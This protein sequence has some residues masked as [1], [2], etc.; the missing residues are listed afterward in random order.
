M[1]RTPKQTRTAH[2]APA[3][4]GRHIAVELTELPAR[5]LRENKLPDVQARIADCRGTGPAEKLLLLQEGIKKLLDFKI[6]YFTNS[7][8]L[9]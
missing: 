9:S 2:T 1:P 8:L 4:N 5:G 3:T 6:N 7:L